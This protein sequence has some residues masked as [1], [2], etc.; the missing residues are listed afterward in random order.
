MEDI[1]SHQVGGDHYASKAVQPWEAMESWMSPEAFAGYLQGNC[2]KYLARYRDKNGTQDLKKCQH[3]LAK[4]IEMET[5]LELVVE[6]A[7]S[8]D[9]HHFEAGYQSGLTGGVIANLQRSQMHK[10]W[11]KGYMQGRGEFLGDRHAD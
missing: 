11:M 9:R 5:C 7:D 8:V 6:N 3:Y 1:N 10:D 4:L 2:I